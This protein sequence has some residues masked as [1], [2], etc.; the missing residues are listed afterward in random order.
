M[1]NLSIIFLQTI[2]ASLTGSYIEDASCFDE[3][4]SEDWRALI[5]MAE[6]HKLLPLFY[7]VA[8]VYM[9]KAEPELALA[10]KRRNMQQVMLQTIKT[11]DFLDMYKKLAKAGLRPLVVKGITCRNLYPKPDLRVSSDED[12]LID[13]S[14][15]ED[16]H[17]ALCDIGLYCEDDELVI[18]RSY[19]VSYRKKGSPLFHF[20]HLE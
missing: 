13:A 10:L 11:A 7:E 14:I 5:H 19:E 2:K 16:C 18:E 6:I 17:K 9:E 3:L 20:Q 12:M 4:S 1:D 15:F 8:H